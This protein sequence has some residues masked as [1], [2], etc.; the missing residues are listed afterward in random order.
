MQTTNPLIEFMEKFEKEYD[1]LYIKN[2]SGGEMT[3]TE[4]SRLGVLQK[5]LDD[6]LWRKN[7]GAKQA[8]RMKA[9]RDALSRNQLGLFLEET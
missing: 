6:I 2:S 1:A 8:E 5:E 9:A 4:I 3:P 7:V